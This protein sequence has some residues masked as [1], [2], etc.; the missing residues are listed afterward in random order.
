[1]GTVWEY[2]MSNTECATAATNFKNKK[3][4]AVKKKRTAGIWSKLNTA[5]AADNRKPINLGVKARL[6]RALLVFWLFFGFIRVYF[7][8]TR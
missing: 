8:L 2:L 3:E 1:M 4:Y 6:S 7:Y 5:I